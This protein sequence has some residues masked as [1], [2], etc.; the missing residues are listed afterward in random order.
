MTIKQRFEAVKNKELRRRLLANMRDVGNDTDAPTDRDALKAGFVWSSTPEGFHYWD[1]LDDT[2]EKEVTFD[3]AYAILDGSVPDIPS[4]PPP[5][6]KPAKGY[7]YHICKDNIVVT[8]YI[9]DHEW[10][11]TFDIDSFI[12]WAKKTRNASKRHIRQ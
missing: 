7:R 1:K 8:Q 9:H 10:R 3:R 11:A 5:P 4:T 12:T 2:L 6:P